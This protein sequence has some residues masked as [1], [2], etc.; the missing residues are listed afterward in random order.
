MRVLSEAIEVRS[1]MG[2]AAFQDI[3]GLGF[4]QARNLHVLSRA[5]DASFIDVM[6]PPGYGLVRSSGQGVLGPVRD[7]TF[8][9]SG[10][11][12]VLEDFETG[13]PQ[14]TRFDASGALLGGFIANGNF[15]DQGLSLAFDGTGRLNVGDVSKI[16]RYDS[17]GTYVDSYGVG[18]KGVG[19]LIWPTSMA[20][21][22]VHQTMWVADI[23]QNFV[24]AYTPGSSTQLAQFGGRGPANGQFDANETGTTYYGPNRVAVDAVGNIYA[25]DPAASRLQKFASNGSYLGQFSFGTSRL[26]GAMAIEP[27]SGVIFVGRGARIDVICPF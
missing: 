16:R 11:A 22:P 15:Q 19:K 2:A 6:G 23:F 17:T 26:F 9:A 4:D 27:D 24:E 21:D 3:N 14:I 12:Y 18:G 7:L 13:P 20:W 8:D 5:G 25:S 10:T 1:P